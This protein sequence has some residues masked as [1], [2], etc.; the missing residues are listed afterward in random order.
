M[1]DIFGFA[2]G[3]RGFTQQ[4]WGN[5][6]AS[7]AGWMIWTK[8]RGI[9]M[10]SIVLCG[11][12]S[13]G[14]G[15]AGATAGSAKGGGGGGASGAWAF[16][17]WDAFFVPDTL[18]VSVSPGSPGGAGGSAGNG[19]GSVGGVSSFVGVYPNTAANNV[20]LTA[21]G[22][23][24][25]GAGTTA[26]GGTGATGGA[27]GAAP[28][29]VFSHMAFLRSFLAGVSGSNGGAHTGA[30]GSNLAVG[31]VIQST[32][33]AGGGGSQSA[34]FSGG[35]INAVANTP[36]VAIAGGAAGANNGGNGYRFGK[37]PLF[38]GGSGG[39][40]SNSATGGAGG[41]ASSSPGAGGGGGGGG[42]TVGGRGGDG[43]P[44]LVIISCW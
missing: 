26:A 35:N 14:G 44:G 40:A 29:C 20:F 36:F 17:L 7:G 16:G 22:A 39:G 43:G 24:A 2:S 10:V 12:G 6:V 11:S 19:T 5:S 4:Y 8:P 23:G 37:V 27:A 28:N 1:Q 25:A 41:S 31:T 3:R 30:A 32:G 9:T 33:G 18:Y 13:G 21:A 15:G 34:D 42:T 38:Y